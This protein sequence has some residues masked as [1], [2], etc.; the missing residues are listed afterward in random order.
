MVLEEIKKRQGKQDIFNGY[1]N[2]T[3]AVN[4]SMVDAGRRWY[5]TN[6]QWTRTNSLHNGPRWPDGGI[7]TVSSSSIQFWEIGS[8]YSGFTI[9]H[10]IS[11]QNPML[12]RNQVQ[13]LYCRMFI[14]LLD[15]VVTVTDEQD[16]NTWNTFPVS[17]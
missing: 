15:D 5:R 17:E 6:Q 1:I 4:S 9:I 2:S 14:D 10:A 16:Q 13:I 7:L 11:L 8:V 3:G 12:N